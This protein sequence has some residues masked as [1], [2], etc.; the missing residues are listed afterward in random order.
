MEAFYNVSGIVGEQGYPFC[1]I[2]DDI[3]NATSVSQFA[4]DIE[5]LINFTEAFG[6]LKFILL[7]DQV[8][9]DQFSGTLSND[10]LFYRPQSA[11]YGQQT[12]VSGGSA[13]YYSIPALSKSEI[14]SLHLFYS[15]TTAME[16]LSYDEYFEYA[17]NCISFLRNPFYARLHTA[18][19]G[20]QSSIYNY[21]LGG[22]DDL[23]LPGESA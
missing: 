17:A 1:V 18:L 15:N 10:E 11:V 13:N 4:I 21:S 19:L 20:Y 23:L 9:I 16:P 14:H 22:G 8:S 6:Y 12:E 2:I 3:H 5:K 7:G